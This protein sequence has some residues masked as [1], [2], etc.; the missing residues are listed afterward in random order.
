MPAVDTLTWFE[1]TGRWSEQSRKWNDSDPVAPEPPDGDFTWDIGTSGTEF[2]FNETYGTLDPV[3]IQSSTIVAVFVDSSDD[4]VFLKT[5]NDLEIKS[6]DKITLVSGG[7]SVQLTWN[8]TTLQYEATNTAFTAYVVSQVGVAIGLN[9]T[10]DNAEVPPVT[11]IT[12]SGDTLVGCDVFNNRILLLD[13]DTNND[14]IGTRIERTDMAF[15]GQERVS[16]ITR[17]YPHIQG[18]EPVLIWLGSQDRPG[19]P[20]RWKAPV[21]FDPDT[22]RKVDIRTTGSLH[23]WRI[24]SLGTGHWV[25]SGFDIEYTP[26]GKR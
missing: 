17:M 1:W 11:A 6:S 14:D 12:A 21:E 25:L 13:P 8:G 26:S 4:G 16:T 18:T 9:I 24:E 19:A 20:V 22:Q 23:C 2:G 15:D 10:I 7:N 3:I 5:S